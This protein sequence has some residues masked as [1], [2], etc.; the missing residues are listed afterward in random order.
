MLHTARTEASAH[1]F[2]DDNSI[3]IIKLTEKL[4]K[5]QLNWVQRKL[6]FPLPLQLESL[7]DSLR[8][9][10]RVVIQNIFQPKQALY[11]KV[12]PILGIWYLITNQTPYECTIS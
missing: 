5:L 11:R 7:K 2:E 3:A 10:E 6:P 9:A 12:D 8:I 4:Q 1:E